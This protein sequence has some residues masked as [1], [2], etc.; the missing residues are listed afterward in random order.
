MVELSETLVAQTD[1]DSVL[2]LLTDRC[3]QQ[4]D[5]DAAGVLVA[6]ERAVLR[7]LAASPEHT[8]RVTL[9][10]TTSAPGRWCFATG[11]PVIDTDLDNPDPRWV[12]F[13]GLAGEQ[14]FRSVA[15]LPMRARGEVI[16][17]LTLLRARVGPF[18]G[19]QLRLAQA[20][21]N[22]ATVALLLRYDA[23]YRSVVAAQAQRVL[24]GRVAIERARGILA[25]LLDMDVDTAL[26]EL[27]RHAERTQRPLS[28]TAAEVVGV[29]HLAGRANGATVM[30]IYRITAGT[31]APL[32]LLIQERLAT[33][34]LSGSLAEAF[35]LAI[36][37]AAVNA[38]EYAGGGRLWLW[39]HHGDL[40][41]EISDDGPGLPPG[42]AIRTQAP[43]SEDHD[44]AGLWLIRRICPDAQI[45]S[46]PRGMRLL[47]RQPLP[48]QSAVSLSDAESDLGG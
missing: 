21:A 34:G 1:V 30:L 29:G 12:A 18:T 10:E 7:L 48:L 31:M 44:H 43:S 39:R 46:S 37:E 42:F 22:V 2:H 25:E 5:A 45:I 11:K 8:A 28:A 47:L 20:L 13:A 35:K 36:H 32:R 3:L 27:R 41:C 33:A 15:A 26:D 24:T 4:L 40:W 19:E 38:Q 16:G 6:D 14:G 17:V 23:G 9:F